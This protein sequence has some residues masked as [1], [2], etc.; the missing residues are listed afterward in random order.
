M[1]AG[2]AVP[3]RSDHRAKPRNAGVD[4]SD[5]WPHNAHIFWCE[6]EKH[7][8]IKTSIFIFHVKFLDEL[9]LNSIIESYSSY[10]FI[11]Y[12]KY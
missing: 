4:W 10:I 5:W 2:I 9:T 1:L 11:N 12:E 7:V 8:L 6:Q 3:H